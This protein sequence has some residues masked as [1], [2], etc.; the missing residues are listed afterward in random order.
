LIYTSGTTFIH[1][2]FPEF[3]PDGSILRRKA[4]KEGKAPEELKAEWDRARDE[5]CRFGTRVHEVC[6]DVVLGRTPRNEPASEKERLTFAQAE[7]AAS[8]FRRGLDVLAAEKMVAAPFLPR[9]LAGTVDLLARSRKDGSVLVLDWKTNK[10]IDRENR[11]GR[12]GLDPIKHVPDT[13]LGH[14]E[15]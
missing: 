6:E 12:F 13:P 8:L 9:P 14:Y 15:C 7:A 2:F 10:S 11:W 3:D 1:K 4:L 5:S